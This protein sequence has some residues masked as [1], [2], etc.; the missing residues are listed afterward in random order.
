MWRKDRAA[1]AARRTRPKAAKPRPRVSLLSRNWLSPKKT[2][3]WARWCR[4][5]SDWDSIP[6]RVAGFKMDPSFLVRVSRPK[7]CGNRAKVWKRSAAEL[8]KLS[9]PKL[10]LP[11][12]HLENLKLD[13]SRPKPLSSFRDDRAPREQRV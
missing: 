12:R 5:K 3:M 8:I 7:S 2:P 4:P 10:E 13:R 1:R 9:T 6:A 11:L